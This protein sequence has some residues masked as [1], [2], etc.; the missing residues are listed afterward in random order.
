MR[1][2]S[3]I[4]V[5]SLFVLTGCWDKNEIEEQALVIVMG[6]DDSEQ[7]E[8]VSVTFQI[9]NPQV[10]IPNTGGEKEEATEIITF[11]A[12]DFITARDLAN[13]SVARRIDF[14]HT[15]VIVIGEEFMKKEKAHKFLTSGIRDIEIRRDI[16]VIVS[17][18]KASEF[19][20]KND[21]KLETRPHKFY[22]LMVGRWEETGLVPL[23]DLQRFFQRI[24]SKNDG[25]LSI[26]A[27]TEKSD[28]KKYGNEDDYLP[29]QID[30]QGG[31]TSQLIGSALLRNGVMIGTLT[32][33]ETR[34]ALNLRPISI[35]KY[36]RVTY[37]DPLNPK[38]RISA[39]LIKHRS[40][41]IKVLTEETPLKIKVRLP[42]DFNISAVPSGE[43]YVT[44]FKNQEKLRNQIEESLEKKFNE[45]VKKT[46]EEYKVNPFNWSHVA[47]RNF[48]TMQDYEAYN[49]N[50]K[51][52]NADV[53]IKVEVKFTGFGKQLGPPKVNDKEES[54]D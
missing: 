25:Y 46:Q 28:G 40:T 37:L 43:N 52:L 5:I 23:S 45:L 21:P 22:D 4:L 14:A 3:F 33:E 31:N 13:A 54:N 53:D 11:T 39:Q 26:Y 17:K 34:L 15:K 44:N 1:K 6:L 36:M 10:G 24:E 20:N 35:A 42:L 29:G 50:E 51:Y 7:D 48:L 30:Q 41:E 32:G 49:W 2:I 12:P 19:I 47:R 9:A 8:G 16:K 18:E 27:T 38:Y